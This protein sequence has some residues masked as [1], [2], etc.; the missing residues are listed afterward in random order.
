[1]QL[2]V[3]AGQFPDLSRSTASGELDTSP[4]KRTSL[5]RPPSAIATACFLVDASNA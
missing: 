3:A 4:R 1:M 5:P 2:G